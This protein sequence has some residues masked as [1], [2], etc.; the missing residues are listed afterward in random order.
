ME[1]L[2]THLPLQVLLPAVTYIWFELRK[3]AAS[4]IKLKDVEYLWR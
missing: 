3:L 4:A 2:Q 1:I